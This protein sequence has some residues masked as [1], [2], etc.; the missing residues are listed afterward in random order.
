MKT[1]ASKRKKEE[2]INKNKTLLI[3]NFKNETSF[4]STAYWVTVHDQ[5]LSVL[6]GARQREKERE[7]LC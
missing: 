1:G 5:V 2:K 3:S 7:S 4:L 6:N